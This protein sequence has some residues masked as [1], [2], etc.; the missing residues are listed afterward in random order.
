LERL[1]ENVSNCHRVAVTPDV[2][3]AALTEAPD[4]NNEEE[5]V[6]GHAT[7]HA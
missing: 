7:P 2:G 5:K 4:V 1:R 3:T 6:E